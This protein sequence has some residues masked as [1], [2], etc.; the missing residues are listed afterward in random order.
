M[1]NCA[2]INNNFCFIKDKKSS[3]IIN[4][5]NNLTIQQI[6]KKDRDKYLNVSII[7]MS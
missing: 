6:L 3:I 5:E 7:F 2:M 1:G 4:D